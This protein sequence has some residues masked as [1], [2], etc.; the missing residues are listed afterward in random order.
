MGQTVI[1]HPR[2]EK[3]TRRQPEG[4]TSHHH[5]LLLFSLVI[6]ISRQ[7]ASRSSSELLIRKPF[8]E[9]TER[10]LSGWKHL[11]LLKGHRLTLLK[12]TFSSFLTYYLSLFTVPKFVADR[13][14]RIQIDFFFLEGLG[15]CKRKNSNTRQ[16][17]GARFSLLLSLGIRRIGVFNKALLG[18]WLWCVANE[19]NHLLCQVIA[20]KYG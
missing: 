3:G 1:Y 17:L 5:Q 20:S 13:I 19:V 16:W 7:G 2:I 9:K 4:K 15:G 12:S 11:Y 8:L 6:P 10:K 14:E 18:K